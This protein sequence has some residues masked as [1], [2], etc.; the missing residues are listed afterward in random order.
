MAVTGADLV[1]IAVAAVAVAGVIAR[2]WRLPEAVWACGAALLLV[3]TGLLPPSAALEG[4]GKGADVYLFLAGMMVIAEAGRSQGLFDWLAERAVRHAAGSPTRL[5]AAIYAVGTVVTI[6]LSNDATAV[7][8][9]PAVYAA[10]R[11]ARAKPLPY[12][13]ICAFVANAA[14]FVLPMSNPANL[15]VYGEHMPALAEWLAR[16]TLPS[17]A[18]IAATYAVLRITQREALSGTISTE[19]SGASLSP[20]GRLAA[21]GACLMALVLIGAS[22]LDLQLGLPTFLVGFICVAVI[23]AWTGGSPL[24]YVRDVSWG[25]LPLVAGLFMLVEALG[26]TG[27]V[28]ALARYLEMLASISAD[29][30]SWAGGL[31]AALAANVAN[32]LPVGLLAGA[33]VVS[34]HPP[35]SVASALLVGI[36]L[37]PNLSVTGSLATILWLAALR[38]E[39]VHMSAMRFL[40]I[41]AVAMPTALV[42]ALAA[43]TLVG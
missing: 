17:I 41:G 13:L 25:V 36:D 10:A 35:P 43:L 20:G 19:A 3:A 11:A 31:F 7:V 32:N 6:F 18:A 23:L 9:T 37:G 38:R 14:S 12:L 27:T 4:I 21:A 33:T 34:A 26:H 28:G 39:G 22:F 15:V 5:F 30:A 40:R 2:P 24:S 16:F 42:A 8:L 1:V 29:R